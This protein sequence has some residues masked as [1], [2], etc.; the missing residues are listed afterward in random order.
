MRRGMGSVS[1]EATGQGK[2]TK[3]T[4][5]CLCVDRDGE[6]P[7][8]ALRRMG[9]PY[10]R[11]RSSGRMGRSLMLASRRCIRPLSANSQSSLP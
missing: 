2:V 10:Q 1:R 5:K 8:Y 4:L 9:H 11:V 6:A 3:A 7:P